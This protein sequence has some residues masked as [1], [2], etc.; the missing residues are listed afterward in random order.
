LSNL[1]EII[2]F[3]GYWR[4]K[5]IS[6]IPIY[7][8]IY[9]VYSCEKIKFRLMID[10]LIYIGESENVN[11]K[12][13]SHV[14]WNDWKKCLN[15]NQ[16]ICFSFAPVKS[17]IR[18]RIKAAII[19]YHKPQL[20]TEYIDH[21]P[22]DKTTISTNGKNKFLKMKFSVERNEKYNKQKISTKS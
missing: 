5:N 22:F 10:K 13:K 6:S 17:S 9:C 20:N 14:K 15:E 2:D 1:S 16:E 3:G 4:E 7:S 12:I 19:N 8:G 18:E 21:F 11:K